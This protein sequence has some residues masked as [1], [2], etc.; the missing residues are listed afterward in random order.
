[1]AAGLFVGDAALGIRLKYP[2]IKLFGTLI[3]GVPYYFLK[4]LIFFSYVMF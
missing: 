2:M 1:M 3:G 4:L